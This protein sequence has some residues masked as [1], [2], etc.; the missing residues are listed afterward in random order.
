MQNSD[1]RHAD[2]SRTLED[3]A[4]HLTDIPFREYIGAMARQL[5]QLARAEGGGDESLAVALEQAAHL[6]AV[7]RE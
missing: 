7:P 3:S 2:A 1:A 6:A 5:A 4:T